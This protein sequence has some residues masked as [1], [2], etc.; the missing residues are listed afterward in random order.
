MRAVYY[1]THGEAQVLQVGELERPACGSTQVLAELA[2]LY[3]QGML[4]RC[5]LTLVAQFVEVRA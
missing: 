1:A 3:E 4:P 5:R 2:A